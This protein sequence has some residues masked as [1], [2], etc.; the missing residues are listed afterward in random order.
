MLNCNECHFKDQCRERFREAKKHGM[1]PVVTE[2]EYFEVI[3][4]AE[5]CAFFIDKRRV[6]ADL[7]V[8]TN[9]S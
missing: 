6:S 3:G 7:E 2:D 4:S 8:K 1:Y 5:A 9:D